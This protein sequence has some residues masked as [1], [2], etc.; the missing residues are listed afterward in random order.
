MSV[1]PFKSQGSAGTQLSNL[2]VTDQQIAVSLPDA[3]LILKPT[4]YNPVIITKDNSPPISTTNGYYLGIG[5][6]EYNWMTPNYRLIGFGWS[7]NSDGNHPDGYSPGEH[8]PAFIGFEETD[9]A[10]S[11]VGD[12]IFGTRDTPDTPSPPK[13]RLRIDSTGDIHVYGKTTSFIT[14][15]GPIPNSNNSLGGNR[16]FESIVGN[17]DGTMFAVGST[18]KPSVQNAPFGT[19]TKLDYDG[20]IMW[21]KSIDYTSGSIPDGYPF[22]KP[23]YYADGIITIGGALYAGFND[24]T[25][26][27][28]NVA[29]MSFDPI[30]GNALD[31]LYLSADNS[32]YIA[33]IDNISGV[34]IVG[35]GA[36][37]S[38]LNTIPNVFP[39]S[40]SKVSILELPLSLFDPNN[41]PTSDGQWS[42]SGGNI[43]STTGVISI[44]NFRYV[45][46]DPETLVN[47]GSLSFGFLYTDGDSIV[48][49]AGDF[50][51]EAWIYV[52]S[53]LAFQPNGTSP[54]IADVISGGE[55]GTLECYI[56][57][58]DEN[59]TTAR[60][61][62]MRIIDNAGLVE[63]GNI[64]LD[65]NTW[66]HL[67][68]Q[69]A[70]NVG[71]IFVNGV[72]QSN[73]DFTTDMLTPVTTWIGTGNN[74]VSSL[75]SDFP[76]LMTNIRVS[77]AFVY[78]G[79]FSV[80]T[81]P[82]DN[83]AN[84]QLL[85]N[86][87]SNRPTA[88]GSSNQHLIY[89]AIQGDPRSPYQGT[90]FTYGLSY[91]AIGGILI[92][93]GVFSG[94][95]GYSAGDNLIT[96]GTQIGGISPDNDI[97]VTIE[98]VG[99][100]GE[101]TGVNFTGVIP[102]GEITGNIYL[103]V[104]QSID[105][106]MIEQAYNVIQLHY[107][108]AI[109]ATTNWQYSVGGDYYSEFMTVSVD[110]GN[111]V[112]ASGRYG[113]TGGQSSNASM[114]CKFNS[115]GVFQWAKSV[116]DD[117]GYGE[118]FASAINSQDK[119]IVVGWN[120]ANLP[121]VTKVDS[122]GSII[123]Q[124]RIMSGAPMGG[125]SF[126]LVLD[127][128][129]NI[130]FGG[131]FGSDFSQSLD[132]LIIKLDTD[133]NVIWQRSLGTSQYDDHFY[134]WGANN[135][136]ISGDQYLMCGYTDFYDDGG[137]HNSFVASFPLD[138]SGPGVYGNWTYNEQFWDFEYTSSISTTLTP[139]VNVLELVS[140]YPIMKTSD[141]DEN[142]LITPV[143]TSGGNI[144]NIGS[145]AFTGYD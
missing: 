31:T 70:N 30:T 115:D 98:T 75:A 33:D 23:I 8:P 103:T 106:S 96:Y 126:S 42:V 114:I 46:A 56:R 9:D 104:D 111:N 22:D 130:L 5:G 39:L 145:L 134:D 62:G 36:K 81:G 59:D 118:L 79:N 74:N 4:G 69:R 142:V 29:I 90:G 37:Y 24:Y 89:S 21:Q 141:L 14:V 18:Y 15:I 41:L 10:G 73:S 144:V 26:D 13:I 140:T 116:D 86:V 83:T 20:S 129:D 58:Y 137:G 52:N 76:G 43:I 27:R 32:V 91:S 78:N 19:I 57:S 109:I 12:L 50:T 71:T 67:V 135:F 132:M 128:Q 28:S 105:F 125:G 17:S 61:I 93:Y 85:L 110:S 34:S 87:L 16:E 136:S 60:I 7:E 101:V 35:V 38:N 97:I 127:E 100:S 65:Q 117:S 84:T 49:G 108:D 131:D 72:S 102:D 94:G 80:P 11:T 54:Y 2:L 95:A 64:T 107:E 40:D 133:G 25:G 63:T 124:I 3:A 99:G 138:G 45:S 113:G 55:A 77:N 47:G 66:I 143:S 53:D 123:W 68:F 82:L 120:D 88:D 92:D 44:N 119:L 121:I 6:Y 1:Q 48:S 122:D 51:V 139:E 112:Y